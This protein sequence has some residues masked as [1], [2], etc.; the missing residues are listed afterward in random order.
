MLRSAST[1]YSCSTKCRC[2]LPPV[3]GVI[4]SHPSTPLSH[5][6]LLA[7]GWGIPNAYVKNAPALL[8]QY[9]GW[10]VEFDAKRDGYSIKRAGSWIELQASINARLSQRLDVMKPRFNLAE[11]RLLGLR[12]QRAALGASLLAASRRTL[13]R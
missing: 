13:A 2:S 8:K 12:Q 10:W 4:T 5:I 11:T 9:D 6:N 7:K 1:K 3:A